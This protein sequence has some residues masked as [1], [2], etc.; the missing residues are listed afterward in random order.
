MTQ[1]LRER[2]ALLSDG[3]VEAGAISLYEYENGC[4]Q[5]DETGNQ[6]GVSFFEATLEDQERAIDQF[7]TAITAA[8]DHAEKV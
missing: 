4:R 6:G 7:A 1:T 2:V 5:M 3:A 8:L